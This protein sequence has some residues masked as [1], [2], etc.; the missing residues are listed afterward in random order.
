MGTIAG[1]H[2][3][4]LAAGVNDSH[5]IVGWTDTVA[6]ANGQVLQRAFVY[7][8]GTMYNLTFYLVGGPT[9]LRSEAT[10]I[11]AGISC[12][13]TAVRLRPPHIE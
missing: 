9:V 1:N 6:S 2:Y 13:G 5:E 3:N 10:Q 4:S 11:D 12:I 7:M 8:G